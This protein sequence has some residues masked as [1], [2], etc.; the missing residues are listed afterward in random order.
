M[1]TRERAFNPPIPQYAEIFQSQ[2][3]GQVQQS[4]YSL[5]VLEETLA[6]AN[7]T[8]EAGKIRLLRMVTRGDEYLL[9][10]RNSQ[11]GPKDDLYP[12][13]NLYFG[14]ALSTEGLL[15]F[16]IWQSE[17]DRLGIYLSDEDVARAIQ[18]ET[19]GRL[20]NDD[21]LAIEKALTPRGQPRVNPTPALGEEFRVRLAQTTLL[22]F[23]PGGIIKVPAPVTPAELWNYYKANR[24][25]L[26]V[27][28][29]PIP[30]SKFIDQVKDKP[31]EAELTKLF[32]EYKDAEYYPQRNAPSFKQSRRIKVEWIGAKTDAP[33]YR[34]EA[35]QWVMSVLALTPGNPWMGMALLDNVVSEYNRVTTRFG[36]GSLKVAAWTEPGFA[37]SFATY[38]HWQRAESAAALVGQLAGTSLDGNPP[39]R[40]YGFTGGSLRS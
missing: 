17:A 2:Y 20:T 24:T 30:V 34:K 25:E 16:K 10:S 13:Y 29:L 9:Q 31:T 5:L 22:G 18:E 33:R 6:K 7:K 27:K 14:G 36:D 40:R 15:D 3:S 39:R 35:H 1:Q 32:D 21:S 8:V 19:L 12:E 38:A 28:F 37:L 4:I 23:D 11:S 26:A